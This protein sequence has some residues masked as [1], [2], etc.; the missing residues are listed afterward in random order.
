MSYGQ[1][2]DYLYTRSE[3]RHEHP[4]PELGQAIMA[5]EDDAQEWKMAR[6]MVQSWLGLQSE[7]TG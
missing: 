1:F 2:D 3:T 7:V 4:S 6:E 5:E